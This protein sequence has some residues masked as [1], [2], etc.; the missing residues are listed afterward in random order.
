MAKSGFPKRF[1]IKRSAIRKDLLFF[2]VP[3]LIVWILEVSFCARDG[4]TGFWGTV[5]GLVRQP[6][7]LF[8]LP[9][10]SLIGLALFFVGLS[11]M[12]VSQATLW[13]YYSSSLV[14][15]EDHK[16]I[17]HGVYRLVR[18]PIYLGLIMVA[19]GLPTY[20]QSLSGFITSSILIPIILVRINLEE[21]LLTEEFKDAFQDYKETT[22]RLI[23]FIY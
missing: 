13:R 4:L 19:I 1:R 16:L 2:G 9:V 21:R 20:V 3:A 10:L 8:M 12:L 5:W 22:K 11:L 7:N 17:T 18:N 15:R 6:Q 14:I 23:P